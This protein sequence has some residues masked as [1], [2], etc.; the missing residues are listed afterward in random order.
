LV[1][2]VANEGANAG[3]DGNEPLGVKVEASLESSSGPRFADSKRSGSW[4]E[5]LPSMLPMVFLFFATPTV[6]FLSVCT[7]PFQ[8]PDEITHFLRSYQVSVGELYGRG[9]GY[10]DPG[11]LDAYS[12]YSGL[13]FKPD[14]RVTAADETAAADLKWTSKRVRSDFPNTSTSPPFGYIAQALAIA[15]GRLADLSV[16]HTLMLARL[17]N[18]ALAIFISFFSLHWCRRG[19]LAMFAV[20]LLP[21]TLSLFAS[22]SHDALLISMACLAFSL[23]SRQISQNLPLSWP[24]TLALASALLVVA[25]GRPPY[26]PLLLVLLIPGLVP[27]WGR[28]PAWLTGLGLACASLSLIVIWWLTAFSSASLPPNPGAQ[29]PVSARLQLLFM[30]HHPTILPALVAS[31]FHYLVGYICGFIGVLGWLDTYM[32]RSY[33]GIMLLVL[34]VAV[35]GETVD[36]SRFENR[37]AGVVFF[38][39]LSTLASVFLIEYLVWTPVGAQIVEGIQGRYF[40]PLA[41]AAGIALPCVAKWEWGYRW[42]AAIVVLS[43]PLTFLYLPKVIIERYYLR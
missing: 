39:A 9:G 38:A 6:I 17:L 19:K 16:V 10:V 12:H 11:I 27:R 37:A 7:P 32:P 20:L 35:A 42:A 24:I 22:S 25:L 31:S 41:I 43:Q 5:S 34:L 18:G 15:F 29:S 26:A 1:V 23:L 40:I 8:S 30:L 4:L 36:V 13:P 3:C 2:A 21:M 33:Y 28:K 14:A